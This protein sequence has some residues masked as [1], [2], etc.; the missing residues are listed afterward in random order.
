[1]SKF[2]PPTVGIFF[3]LVFLASPLMIRAENI[4]QAERLE[5]SHVSLPELSSKQSLEFWVKFKN[6]GTQYWRGDGSQAV[7]LRTV[8]GTKSK[9]YH[10]TWYNSYTP[11]RV[12]PVLTIDS[13][14]EA[15]F[16]FKVTAPSTPGMQWEKFNLFA[17]S[18]IILGGEIEIAIHVLG[19]AGKISEPTITPEP[20]PTPAPKPEPVPVPE[21]KTESYFWQTIPASINI[22]KQ[23]RWNEL[24]EGP[25]IRVGLL[26]VDSEEKNDYLPFKIS[27]STKELYNI[28]DQNDKLLVRNTAGEIIEIDYN[29]N[30]GY[31]FL[32]DANGKRLLMTDSYIKLSSGQNNIFKI[33]SW[34]NGPFW[35]QNV[36]DNE[37]RGDIEVKYNPSTGRLWL[38][39]ELSLEKYLK[40]VAEVS[41]LAPFEFLKAQK[42]AARTYA[43]F[44]YLTPK[45][46]N[47]PSGDP[48]FTLQSTQADQVYRG[49]NRELRSPYTSQ[50]VELTRGIVATYDNDPILAYYFAHSNGSTLSSYDANMTAAPVAYLQPK[51]DPPSQG[52]SMLGH[53]VGLPQ[54]GGMAAARQGANYSQILKY[55]YT[56]IDLTQMY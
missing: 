24:L 31:Y 4:Y 35:G 25:Q 50:A 39:N 30:T 20:K 49:Y 12:N 44:R 23:S 7:T 22:N 32:N 47:T 26:Y 9:F 5:Q 27:S 34:N 19:E 37:F 55:Y 16:R 1:M 29:Y 28:Y 13:G 15:L 52:Q 40:G 18:T 11:N 42:I 46:T 51:L 33:N 6:I 36:N 2:T 56:G 8:N 14:D 3:L 43:I 21:P 17:G 53:G 54:V 45:Y 41:D 48:F 10:S 38:I